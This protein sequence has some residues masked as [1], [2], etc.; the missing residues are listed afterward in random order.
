MLDKKFG[1][2]QKTDV[3]AL[4]LES[5][6]KREEKWFDIEEYMKAGA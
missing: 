3:K 6:E 5:A 1:P 4:S 2:Q